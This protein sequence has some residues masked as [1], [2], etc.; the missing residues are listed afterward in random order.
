MKKKT[1][2][3]LGIIA[4]LVLSIILIKNINPI[5]GNVIIEN[6]CGGADINRDGS[7]NLE[8]F[9]ILKRN[10]GCTEDS[11]ECKNADINNDG[12]V[13]VEDF[14]VFKQNYL[15]ENCLATPVVI[16][17]EEA[18][19]TGN[20]SDRDLVAHLNTA[21]ERTSAV[22]KEKY[23]LMIIFKEL[24]GAQVNEPVTAQ[25][26]CEGKPTPHYVS[27]KGPGEGTKSLNGVMI[28][29]GKHSESKKNTINC[30][31]KVVDYRYKE[32]T[33]E[34][35]NIIQDSMENRTIFLEKETASLKINLFNKD[36]LETLNG[37]A[38]LYWSNAKGRDGLFKGIEILNGAIEIES[39][40][41]GNC[42]ISNVKVGDS[43]YF[44]NAKKMTLTKDKLTNINIPIN[45]LNN[46]VTINLIDT[47]TG[48]KVI[49]EEAR[50]IIRSE[51][52]GVVYSSEFKNGSVVIGL[53]TGTYTI[54]ISPPAGWYGQKF[55]NINVPFKKATVLRETIKF[56]KVPREID[57]QLL[58]DGSLTMRVIDEEGRPISGAEVIV[59]G[60]LAESGQRV[61]MIYGSNNYATEAYSKDRSLVLSNLTDLNGRATINRLTLSYLQG[62]FSLTS[63]LK[64]KYIFGVIHEDYKSKIKELV[65]TLGEDYEFEAILK[66]GEPESID[67]YCKD[68]KG[69]LLIGGIAI[70]S[71]PS[72]DEYIIPS[73]RNVKNLDNQGFASFPAI[74]GFK[75]IISCC[76]PTT[77]P[78][79]C[80]PQNKGK[81]F[82]IAIIGKNE[83]KREFHLAK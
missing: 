53:P 74:K 19:I 57:Y 83:I 3:F 21:S 70:L 6:W 39:I 5:T 61:V 30:E 60:K 17:N 50:I 4:I 14:T 8:D 69:D 48:R 79:W 58:K 42:L 46:F 80:F 35:F 31:I 2:I 62:S 27:D 43:I 24:D 67:V 23:S 18:I 11:T 71:H 55:G 54:E 40:F 1:I 66:S 56:T 36:T 76:R 26:F 25:L 77:H 12:Q 38:D 82:D 78:E 49:E 63:V 20:T 81:D 33:S 72:L 52:K 44:I 7:V 64:E 32:H 59:I 13:D 22:P 65:I 28:F 73:Y 47:K 16:S 10:L 75:Y 37:S 34:K 9:V 51:G 68:W 45:L 41:P 29:D 15:L